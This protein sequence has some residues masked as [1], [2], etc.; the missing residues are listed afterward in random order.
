MSLVRFEIQRITRRRGSFYGSMAFSTLIAVIALVAG[1][2]QDEALWGPV[3]GTG[4]VMGASIIGALA[5]SYDNAEGT[6]RYLVLTGTP[7][8]R[9]VALRVPA[10]FAALL[11]MVVP[12]ALVAIGAMASDGQTLETIARLVGGTVLGM[13]AWGLVSMCVGTMLRSNGAGIA[14][15]LVLF[16]VGNLLTE[17]VR[18]K[19]SQTAGDYLLTNVGNVVSSLGHVSG[20]MPPF[21]IGLA[22]ASVALVIWLAAFLGAAILRVERD[23]Y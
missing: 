13:L 17:F 18:D 16:L 2:Q 14:V 23:E 21:T 7:R 15:A 19:V 5:G 3:L 1:S 10:L 8:S 20:D 11:L 9:L 22:A 6:M 12:A 4:T